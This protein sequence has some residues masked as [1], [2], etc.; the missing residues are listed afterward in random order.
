MLSGSSDRPCRCRATLLAAALLLLAMLEIGC[1]GPREYFRNGFKVGPNYR[2]P[3][4]PVAGQWID[5]D[6]PRVQSQEADDSRWWSV[7]Q[8]PALEGLVASAYEQNLSLREAGNRV[9]V[10]RARL[11]VARGELFP[12]QQQA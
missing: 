2:R 11:G 3:A 9:L 1:T 5:A 7:L 6:D 4:A 8:D 10:A 12:Q